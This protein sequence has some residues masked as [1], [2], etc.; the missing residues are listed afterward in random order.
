MHPGAHCVSDCKWAT[1]FK[2]GKGVWACNAM[3]AAAHFDLTRFRALKRINALIQDAQREPFDG[4]SL[5]R[6]TLSA[7]SM[8]WPMAGD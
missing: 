3:Y 6:R 2:H 7:I 5:A 8:R 4:L 1:F